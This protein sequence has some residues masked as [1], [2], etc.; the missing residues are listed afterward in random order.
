MEG[1]LMTCELCEREVIRLTTHHLV[2]KL[3]GGKHGP[4]ARLCPTCHRQVH[5]LFTE[6]TL[7]KR[8]SSVVELKAEPQLAS[9]VTWVRTRAGGAGFRVRRS[10]D[11][12]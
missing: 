2:P 4:R 10:N 5:A 7:A 11:R 8:L 1:A 12:S 3:K 6:A 9:Y